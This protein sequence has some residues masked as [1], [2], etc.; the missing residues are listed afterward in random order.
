MD[1]ESKMGC[2]FDCK[3]RTVVL[4]DSVMATVDW[5]SMRIEGFEEAFREATNLL[6]ERPDEV[7]IK[8]LECASMGLGFYQHISRRIPPMDL[9]Y[10]YDHEKVHV[11]C[12]AM[13]LRL[14]IAS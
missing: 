7:G 13:E 5:L 1:K 4:E 2:I 6:A 14:K 10:R 9:I 11:E 12:V 3:F 8:G